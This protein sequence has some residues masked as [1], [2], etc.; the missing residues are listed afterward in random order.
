ME[1]VENRDKHIFVE[2]CGAQMLLFYLRVMVGSQLADSHI[3]SYL[4]LKFV[5]CNALQRGAYVL[6]LL[7]KYM[8]QQKTLNMSHIN[9]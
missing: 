1:T 6:H 8:T 5:I 3:T 4:W 7:V 2:E 9:I